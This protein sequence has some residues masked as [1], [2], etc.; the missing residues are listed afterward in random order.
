MRKYI[1]KVNTVG[2]LEVLT[3]NAGTVTDARIWTGNGSRWD[4]NTESSLLPAVGTNFPAWRKQNPGFRK[5]EIRIED[6]D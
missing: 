5:T 4:S 1:K 6:L 3:T 2:T